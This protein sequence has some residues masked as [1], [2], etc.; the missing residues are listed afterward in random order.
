VWLPCSLTS[1]SSI[2][3]SPRAF[4]VGGAQVSASKALSICLQPILLP[5]SALRGTWLAAD[6][7]EK[8]SWPCSR[9]YVT[10]FRVWKNTAARN[11]KTVKMPTVQ[12]FC[13]YA[14]GNIV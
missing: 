8:A 7:L 11:P 9:P 13:S 2:A 1:A 5:W 14:S 6:L 3:T 4:S 10:G 12:T